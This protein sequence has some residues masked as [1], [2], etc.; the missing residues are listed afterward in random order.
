MKNG[1]LPISAPFGC[2]GGR[3]ERASRDCN[4]SKGR[5]GLW[6]GGMPTKMIA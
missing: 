5:G 4:D 6:L 1:S 3:G 2:L